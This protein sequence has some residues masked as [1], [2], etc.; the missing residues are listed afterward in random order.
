M[1]DE[2]IVIQRNRYFPFV[3]SAYDGNSPLVISSGE[4]IV[5]GV[6]KNPT[7]TNCVLK[8]VLTS[9]NMTEIDGEY[10]VTLTTSDTDIDSGRYYYDIVYKDSSGELHPIIQKQMFVVADCVVRSADT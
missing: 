7:D 10:L 9:S 2:C 6:K 3:I 5:F 8:K 4:K 1:D